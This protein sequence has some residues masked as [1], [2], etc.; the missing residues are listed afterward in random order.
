MQRLLVATLLLGLASQAAALRS[1]RVAEAADAEVAAAEDA[2]LLKPKEPA[3]G[4]KEW[5]AQRRIKEQ[6]D[7]DAATRVKLQRDKVRKAKEDAKHKEEEEAKKAA[8]RK[9]A[10]KPLEEQ[11]AKEKV[12]RQAALKI[13]LE[14]Q[15]AAQLQ[16]R[17]DE[18]ETIR[19]RQVR[20]EAIKKREDR[21][22]AIQKKE[23]IAS[24]AVDIDAK[25]RQL[26]H[27]KA[28]RLYNYNRIQEKKKILEAEKARKMEQRAQ[29][30]QKAS[31]NLA[32]AK[33]R[34]SEKA[35]STGKVAAGTMKVNVI[36][37]QE[38]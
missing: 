10:N 37:S 20:R 35:K 6:A 36:D 38:K 21:I 26:A 1:G 9:L 22:K 32:L 16:A 3:V 27:D 11:W 17:V 5:Y 8:Q 25:R 33:S 28:M 23:A 31:V 4:S 7:I 18:L 29:E 14:N 15:R 24:G 13:E 19:K 2:E 30:S 12:A 34:V